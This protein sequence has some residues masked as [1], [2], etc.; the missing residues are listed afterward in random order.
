MNLPRACDSERRRALTLIGTGVV[1]GWAVVTT[2]PDIAGAGG[3]LP[4]TVYKEPN[5]GCCGLWADYLRARGF[6]VKV[7]ETDDLEPVKRM[8]R[9]PE[10]LQTCHTAFIGGYVIEGHVP[11]P[12]IVKLLDERPSVIGIA[13]PGMPAGSPGMPSDLLEPYDVFAYTAD[14]TARNY[15]SF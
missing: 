15:M 10:E 9:V 1:A 13:V 2:R 5:C 12:A 4:V 3:L 11:V 6:A 8:A 7:V 14:G